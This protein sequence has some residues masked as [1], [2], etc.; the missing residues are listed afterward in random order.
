MS[1]LHI[2]SPVSG[3]VTGCVSMRDTTAVSSIRSTPSVLC[4]RLSGPDGNK[5][6][7]NPTLVRQDGSLPVPAEN[8]ARRP[9]IG[10]G[11]EQARMAERLVRSLEKGPLCNQTLREFEA[12][13]DQALRADSTQ[14]MR[15]YFD[16]LTRVLLLRP[17][18]SSLA[19]E[20]SD[21]KM[22]ETMVYV[23]NQ[24]LD[25]ILTATNESQLRAVQ[26]TLN[27]QRQLLVEQGKLGADQDRALNAMEA[28][29]R[30]RLSA[31]SSIA[32]YEQKIMQQETGESGA[33]SLQK[34]HEELESTTQRLEDK[35]RAVPL[36]DAPPLGDMAL[37]GLTQRMES[38][39]TRLS[40]LSVR[41]AEPFKDDVIALLEEIRKPDCNAD[42]LA[43][44]VTALKNRLN[45]QKES[46]LSTDVA[47]L[48]QEI[49]KLEGALEVV[50]CEMEAKDALE[51]HP[52]SGYD[53]QNVL[54]DLENR[55]KKLNLHDTDKARLDKVLESLE[56]RINTLRNEEK[57]KIDAFINSLSAQVVD[58]QKMPSGS[59]RTEKL[60]E[61]QKSAD[62]RLELL[63]KQIKNGELPNLTREDG[64]TAQS[65]LKDISQNCIVAQVDEVFRLVKSSSRHAPSLAECANSLGG[66]NLEKGRS[67]EIERRLAASSEKSLGK[68]NAE[69]TRLSAELKQPKSAEEL[70]Q[71]GSRVAE[72]AE[73]AER[74]LL[75]ADK[76]KLSDSNALDILKTQMNEALFEVNIAPEL[77]EGGFLA[78]LN[79][80]QQETLKELCNEA[81][82][83][84]SFL[85]ALK[86][87]KELSALLDAVDAAH[88]MKQAAD[89]E[90]ASR[91]D[92]LFLSHPELDDVA[93]G[94]K[95]SCV[96]E[97]QQEHLAYEHVSSRSRREI[98]SLIDEFVPETVRRKLGLSG[99][100]SITTLR[101][102]VVTAAES[103]KFKKI[104]L[105]LVQSLWWAEKAEKPDLTF[106]EFKET[107]P[108]SFKHIDNLEN[109]LSAGV[110]GRDML[111]Q[112]RT[113]LRKT[114]KGFGNK[115]TMMELFERQ[116]AGS[117]AKW[118]AARALTIHVHRLGLNALSGKEAMQNPADVGKALADKLG[119]PLSG[120]DIKVDME[121]LNAARKE[122]EHQVREQEKLKREIAQNPFRQEMLGRLKGVM[123]DDTVEKLSKG[124][125]AEGKVGATFSTGV[126]LLNSIL[127][128]E[129]VPEVPGDASPSGT[130]QD[131]QR[132]QDL[133]KSLNFQ[134]HVALQHMQGSASGKSDAGGKVFKATL[135]ALQVAKTQDE[136]NKASNAMQSLIKY[137]TAV[138]SDRAVQDELNKLSKSNTTANGTMLESMTTAGANAE[139]EVSLDQKAEAVLYV[140]HFNDPSAT[141]N[142]EEEFGNA[143]ASKTSF[144]KLPGG[145]EV[146]HGMQVQLNTIGRLKQEN[147]SIREV[148][149]DKQEALERF[150]L[151]LKEAV[152]NCAREE[153]KVLDKA[154]RLAICHQFLNDAFDVEG[155]IRER[156]AY[157]DS[158]FTQ[159]P[160]YQRCLD[161]LK[162]MGISAENGGVFLQE[163]LRELTPKSFAAFAREAGRAPNVSLKEYALPGESKSQ[164]KQR[165]RY[166]KAMKISENLA[167]KL[168]ERKTVSAATETAAAINIP[169]L[170]A[171]AASLSVNARAKL[172]SGLNAWKDENGKYHLAFMREGA[173]GVG[174]EVELG[175]AEIKDVVDF[176]AGV[177][178]EGH[179]AKA[180]GCELVFDTEV[181]FQ[182]V[183]A[184][185]I[186]GQASGSLLG[187]CSEVYRLEAKEIGGSV[188]ATA[189]VEV[190]SKFEGTSAPQSSIMSISNGD[191][192]MA[193][194]WVSAGVSAGVSGDLRWESSRN[195]HELVKT[196]TRQG[197]VTATL[198]ASLNSKIGELASNLGTGAKLVGDKKIAD[199]A[200]LIAEKTSI[201]KSWTLGYEERRSVTTDPQ[202]KTLRGAERTR[203]F[204]DLQ[205]PDAVADLLRKQGIPE[206][207][208]VDVQRGVVSYAGTDS[209]SL[210]ITH[211]LDESAVAEC[212][213][214]RKGR[215]P[216]GSSFK[217]TNIKLVVSEGEISRDISL[218]L[219]SFFSFSRA[220]KVG[221]TLTYDYDP[222]LI[223][224]KIPQKAV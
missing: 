74:R 184:S 73:V 41:R 59:Q 57:S 113:S 154:S 107:L 122:Q 199:G 146:T 48:Q 75:P 167:E 137:P 130:V 157:R 37:V 33:S 65:A 163:R 18:T 164:T 35:S 50:R 151:R 62:D 197:A 16:T 45:D 61:I 133:I 24:M 206:K 165:L 25:T 43:G 214:A 156:D 54:T 44:R 177:S 31:L 193:E 140:K 161:E 208:I 221:T 11:A 30:T 69:L 110:S 170:E 104:D 22:R 23:L 189:V 216:S 181:D 121:A 4:A 175:I 68:I 211:S 70:R 210:E 32:G 144:R 218:N 15:T 117:D 138:G 205:H 192:E 12:L 111:K 64:D 8:L 224:P 78:S 20:L 150:D 126:L 172:K 152:K 67:E 209:F 207:V 53:L 84:P 153:R 102:L 135:R 120:V 139:S 49:E 83:H 96:S 131:F 112:V 195:S 198:S 94:M 101:Q 155:L 178:I 200:D 13:R 36:P 17:L 38:L 180:S 202:G 148:E 136:F 191:D 60:S 141:A 134:S 77:K 7:F 63:Q 55:A 109:L 10:P 142:L 215:P 182:R 123:P 27:A 81:G 9:L 100:L 87:E 56:T 82:Y 80:K 222:T 188:E 108:Q 212:N 90:A 143:I 85:L 223:T 185:V 72:L 105:S 176:K 201:K 190:K 219:G 91:L 42:T 19:A 40:E 119:S 129:K 158:D 21:P 58:A 203:V 174:A 194:T 124:G 166:E 162:E 6:A 145:S 187:L 179:A 132:R 76:K 1:Q 66:L 88:T 28:L 98:A 99:D 160:F 86:A 26:G 106:V 173:G 128:M 204:S 149:K 95:Q 169:V 52:H 47:K 147:Q 46:L 220:Q 183:A 34:I 97:E 2:Q 168:D 93:L 3:Q 217:P 127:T 39:E 14:D 118:A 115:N 213:A 29:L 186:A 51:K 5:F 114:V 196:Q 92:S 71:I 89:G 116:L 79:G 103:T 171:G 125:K 159:W